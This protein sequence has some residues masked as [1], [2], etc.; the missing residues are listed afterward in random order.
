MFV[1]LTKS[2]PR[3][4]LQLAESYRD[5]N[6]RVKQRTIASLGRVEKIDAHFDS[7]IRGLRRATG[8]APAAANGLAIAPDD[9][10]VN[11]HFE[12]TRTLGDVWTLTQIWKELG[13]DRLAS[14]FGSSKRKLDVVKWSN[15]DWQKLSK[16]AWKVICSVMTSI[17]KLDALP[18]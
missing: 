16:S 7:V 15:P 4:Y 17:V 6:G 10:Q 18:R 11:I 8:R 3:R 1:K 5:E 9:D 14:V 2:G 13:F 12:P